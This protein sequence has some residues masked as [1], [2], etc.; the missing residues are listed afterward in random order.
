MPKRGIE[1]PQRYGVQGILEQT[2]RKE[3]SNELVD[4]WV[5]VLSWY[6]ACKRTA[7]TSAYQTFLTNETL[8]QAA[9]LNYLSRHSKYGA[10]LEDHDPVRNNTGIFKTHESGSKAYL[11]ITRKVGTGPHQRFHQSA[12][13]AR[14]CEDK[15]KTKKVPQQQP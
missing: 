5:P 3:T 7:E 12:A 1:P 13:F 11:Y 14:E 6:E 10:N 4:Q 8:T 9:F 2:I 15:R